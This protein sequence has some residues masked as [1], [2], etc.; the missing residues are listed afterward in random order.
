MPDAENETIQIQI[1]LL[2]WLEDAFPNVSTHSH[3]TSALMADTT[4]FAVA[5]TLGNNDVEPDYYLPVVANSSTLMQTSIIWNS[6]LTPDEVQTVRLGGYYRREIAPGLLLISLNTVLYS[7]HHAPDIPTSMIDPLEQFAWLGETLDLALQSSF[8]VIIIGHIAPVLDSYRRTLLWQQHFVDSYLAIVETY[9]SIIVGQLFGHVHSDEFRIID[10][11][12]AAA[13][14]LLSGAVT[15]VY[16]N[17]PSFRIVEYSQFD[18]TITDYCVYWLN[19]SEPEPTWAKGY[20]ALEYYNLKAISSQELTR[21]AKDLATNDSTF[22]DFFWVFKAGDISPLPAFSRADWSCLL[23]TVTVSAYQSCMQN[24]T[25]H[26]M[27]ST[28]KTIIGVSSF[29]AACFIILV[30]YFVRRHRQSNGSTAHYDQLEQDFDESVSDIEG[31]AA[32]L[33]ITRFS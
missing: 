20:C 30:I 3:L 26:T 32:S 18:N 16:D 24:R 15:P 28:E 4:E 2:K 17:N 22:E 33:K 21:L 12:S 7:I 9:A 10:P 1:S 13:P 25:S 31:T 5:E 11:T 27:P 19:I 29:V 14:I 8:K 23:Q 6:T